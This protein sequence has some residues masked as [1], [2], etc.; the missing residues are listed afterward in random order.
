MLLP[1]SLVSDAGA[2]LVST[3]PVVVMVHQ[4][5]ILKSTFAVRSSD[6]SVRH[7]FYV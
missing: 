5:R 6:V 3:E 1:E 2:E 4:S 7:L